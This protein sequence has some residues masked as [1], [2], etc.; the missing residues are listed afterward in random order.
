MQGPAAL[1]VLSGLAA[2]A[3]LCVAAWGFSRRP[4]PCAL[5]A[6]VAAFSFAALPVHA[7]GWA[8]LLTPAS[9]AATTAA[10]TLSVIAGTLS[11]ARG[12]R[13]LRGAAGSLALLAREAVRAPWRARSVALAGPIAIVALAG[14]TAV[15]AYYAPSSAW[16]GV[17]YHEPMVGFALQNH[18][19]AWVGVEGANRMLGPVDGYP[20]ITEDLMLFLVAL[21][22]RRVIDLVPSLLLPILLVATYVLLRR[23]VA[24]R[25]AALGLASGMV[26][27]PGIVLQLRSTYVDV[28]F[29]TFVAAALAFLVGR[30]LRA[31]DVWMAGLAIGLAGAS[32]VTGLLVAPLIGAL[33]VT[34][35]AVAARRRPWLLAHLAGAFVL[36][37]AIAAPTYVRNWT[38]TQNLVWP[39]SMTMEPLG[40]EW[41]GPLAI[42]DMNVSGDQAIEWLF[43]PAIPGQQYHDT[44]DNGY[45]DIPPFV[46]LPLAAVGLALALLRSVRGRRDALVLLGLAVPLIATFALSPARH[47]AR[48]NLHVVLALWALA[49]YVIGH[50]RSRLLAEGVSGALILGGLLTIHWAEPAWDVDR[51]RL[52]RLRAMSAEARAASRDGVYT[53]LPPETARARERELGEGDLVVFSSVPFAGLLW[54]ERFSNRVEWIDPRAHRGPAWLDEAARRDA[55]WA[56]VDHRSP[57][58]RL[59]RE[60]AAWEEVGPADGSH[61]PAYAFRRTSMRD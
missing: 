61:D 21:W 57:L 51:E 20:R 8:N 55:E 40:I 48:L 37:L 15:L 5:A 52:A 56:V 33:G 4:A 50:K 34:L 2:L 39:S 43:G 53:L 14:W 27:I 19:F 13:A 38:Q 26:L 60:S 35:V 22:D 46:I 3:G 47:W 28:T 41:E 29:V 36:V 10:L 11:F 54:N 23:F 32:K 31:A 6:G 42:T 24:S 18:G 44:K 9:L 25:V 58:L 49:A 30:D 7:L 12:R 45:G 1:L 16:D 17:M 59:L